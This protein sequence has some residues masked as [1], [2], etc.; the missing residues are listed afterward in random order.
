MRFGMVCNIQYCLALAGR[1]GPSPCSSWHPCRLLSI[2]G[3]AR[4]T[5][6]AGF[7]AQHTIPLDPVPAGADCWPCAAATLSPSAAGCPCC[8]VAR[9]CA[10]WFRSSCNSRAMWLRSSSPMVCG[11]AHRSRSCAGDCASWCACSGDARRRQ[12]AGSGRRHQ[13]GAGGEG[14]LDVRHN[15]AAVAEPGGAL[16][17]ICLN[18]CRKLRLTSSL[19]G[20]PL[21]MTR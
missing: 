3:A 7:P 10:R 16:A 9:S 19:S 15:S 2:Q 1:C 13:L 5:P 14:E 11:A 21:I 8:P 20:L 12:A 18:K 4:R 17:Y 6:G